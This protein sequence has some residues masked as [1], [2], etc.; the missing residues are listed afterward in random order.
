MMILIPVFC[1]ICFLPSESYEQTEKI[2]EAN[3]SSD[4]EQGIKNSNF[5]VEKIVKSLHNSEILSNLVDLVPR[6][7]A[8]S[9]SSQHQIDDEPSPSHY[10]LNKGDGCSISNLNRTLRDIFS[11]PR[12]EKDEEYKNHVRQN[13]IGRF[14]Y[15]STQTHIQHFDARDSS[16]NLVKG[17]NLIGIMPGLNYNQPLDSLLVIGAHY[18]TTALTPGVNDNGSGMA[19]LFETVRLLSPKAG[20]LNN[21]LIFVAFDQEEK[22]CLG[23]MAFVNQFLIPKELNRHGASFTGAFIMDMILN[24]DP[25]SRSQ[26]LP[27]D[28]ARVL[29]EV[30]SYLRKNKYAGDFLGVITRR[31]HDTRLW[32]AYSRSWNKLALYPEHKLLLMDPAIPRVPTF[33]S[34][35]RYRNFVRSDHAAF[36]NH[37]NANYSHNM[38]AVLLTDTGPYRG[39]SRACYHEFCDDLTHIT[40]KNL[41]FMK[42][43]VD[44]LA[45]TILGLSAY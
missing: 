28:M 10:L 19:A 36:W 2:V 35:Y 17:V 26:V 39:V 20:E 25:T 1:A 18:D 9:F 31:G 5:H 24:F 12:N 8:Q 4:R 32:D 37:K 33:F 3:E 30:S 14:A 34:N 13:I 40:Q 29:P 11:K 42:H 41:E 15:Y 45:E 23:S 21:T 44:V 7:S 27:S 38:P 22:G 43:A 16:D 6:S